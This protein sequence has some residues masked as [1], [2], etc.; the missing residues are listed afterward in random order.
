[1]WIALTGKFVI[2]QDIGIAST[3]KLIIEQYKKWIW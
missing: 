2:E 1:M 3:G